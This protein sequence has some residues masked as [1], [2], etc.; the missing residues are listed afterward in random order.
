MCGIASLISGDPTRLARLD[1]MLAVLHKRGPDHLAQWH[2]DGVAMGHTRLSL[3]DLSPAGDQ[4]M[5]LGPWVLSY[6][7]EI[8]NHLELRRQYL[9]HVNF[10]GT[11]DTETLLHLIAER[12]VT[13]ALPLLRGMFAFAVWNSTERELTC[14]VDPFGIKPLY[15]WDGITEFGVASSSAALLKFVPTRRMDAE[16]MGRFF[17]L[18]GTDGVW[19]GI[20]RLHG[21]HAISYRPGGVHQW[22][23]YFPAFNPNAEQELESTIHEALTQVQLAHVPV[24]IFLSGGVDSSLAALCM[25]QGSHAFHLDS[26]ERE[27]AEL[28]ANMAGAQLHIVHPDQS[29]V[30]AA[31]LDIATR[32]GEPTMAGHIPWVVSRC[33][34][35]YVKAAISA[36]GADELF[37]GYDRTA[38]HR[39]ASELLRQDTHMMRSPTSCELPGN[40]H[41]THVDLGDPR[42]P[43]CAHSRWTE[44]MLYV[45]HDLN[46]TLDAASM[47]HS[48]ELRVPYLD[49]KLVECALSLP[50]SF[51]GNK[52]V[53]R[54]LLLR[55]GVPASTVDH[56]K[57][58]FS[59]AVNNPGMVARMDEAV[60]YMERHHGIT[61]HRNASPR[62]K[63]YLRVCAMAWQ[64]WE[65]H[66]KPYMN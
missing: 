25:P 15:Y 11:S 33:A 40:G 19:Q 57:L 7:G 30:V 21:G 26:P 37:F 28:V 45:Q 56:T 43:A 38:R 9:A 63:A 12:G 65:Q 13:G 16:A 1:Q 31:H 47:C 48:L 51:H 66:W 44:L 46:P 54:D 14:A 17:R 3:L 62:D 8:Y 27:H 10:H 24:G 60:R 29:A 18:G 53:L 42:F 36:N 4:P 22:R 5:Q 2:G 64:V 58:G 32:T 34:T 20:N 52:R 41:W 6:N 23:W 61:I 50:H 55:S 39:T 35:E 59:M 49:H